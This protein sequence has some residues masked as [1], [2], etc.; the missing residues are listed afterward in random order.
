MLCCLAAE[1]AISNVRPSK[2][3]IVT[4]KF[5]KALISHNSS[6]KDDFGASCE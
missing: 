3:Y 4:L 5:V 6:I 2:A 1:K